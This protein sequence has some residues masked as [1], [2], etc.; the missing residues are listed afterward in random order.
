MLKWIIHICL[1][2]LCFF[3]LDKYWETECLIQKTVLVSIFQF[4]HRFPRNDWYLPLQQVVMTRDLFIVA[5]MPIAIHWA[6]APCPTDTEESSHGPL[7]SVSM[8]PIFFHT[9]KAPET[10]RGP[11]LQNYIREQSVL[12]CEVISS[13]C[14]SPFSF[15]LAEQPPTWWWKQG[16][17]SCDLVSLHV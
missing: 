12:E 3:P 8:L 14:W 10:P 15:Y 5:L 1:L 16:L 17:I 2:I 13:I 6:P 7:S 11:V 4:S 9:N